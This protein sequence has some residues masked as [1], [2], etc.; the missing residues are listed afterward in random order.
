MDLD[1]VHEVKHPL[2]AAVGDA[3]FIPIA[4]HLDDIRMVDLHELFAGIVPHGQPLDLHDWVRMSRR[5]AAVLSV[6]PMDQREGVLM[7]QWQRLAGQL[8]AATRG[9]P[10]QRV[11]EFQ[12]RHVGSN[13]IV[14]G[15]GCEFDVLGQQVEHA[16]ALAGGV[17]A[18]RGRMAVEIGA[19]PAGGID[20]A[21][22]LFLKS[23]GLAGLNFD[24]SSAR[25][26]I[27]ARD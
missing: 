20:R 4:H 2:E 19:E 9:H 22:E 23:H 11:E 17:V 3:V 13:A 26:R 18:G 7:I 21:S 24:A 27:P 5:P 25:H 8:D 15:A 14:L 12:M 16:A 1:D 10:I 6:R